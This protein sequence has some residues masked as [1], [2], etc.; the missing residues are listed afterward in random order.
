MKHII[1]AAQKIPPFIL[2]NEKF[3]RLHHS[4]LADHFRT[5]LQ[6]AGLLE[7]GHRRIALQWINTSVVE[8]EP[9]P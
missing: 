8:P 5:V 7:S 2:S 1:S 3:Y 4:W 9:E 6:H